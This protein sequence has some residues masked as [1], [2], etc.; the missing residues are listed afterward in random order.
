MCFPKAWG[1]NERFITILKVSYH[2]EYNK[3]IHNSLH[4]ARK[5]ARTLSVPRSKQFSEGEARGKL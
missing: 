3:Y 4:L 1:I 5:Y 2:V